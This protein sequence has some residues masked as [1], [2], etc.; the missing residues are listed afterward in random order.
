MPT[1]AECGLGEPVC[2]AALSQSLEKLTFHPLSMAA[3][4]LTDNYVRQGASAAAA[5][6]IRLCAVSVSVANWDGGRVEADPF[7]GA[8]E[9]WDQLL[10]LGFNII[11]TNDALGLAAFLRSRADTNPVHARPG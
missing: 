2:T 7:P 8:H 6:G 10:K 9:V 4:F 5:A 1:G 3:L 11:E